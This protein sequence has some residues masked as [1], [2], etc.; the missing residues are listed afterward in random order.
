MVTLAIVM[1][2][3][4]KVYRT[5]CH[6]VR[7]QKPWDNQSTTAFRKAQSGNNI[8]LVSRK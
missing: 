7:S 3:V 5:T 2:V 8:L 4:A 6:Q 1:W